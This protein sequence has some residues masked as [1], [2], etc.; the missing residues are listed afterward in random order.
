VLVEAGQHWQAEAVTQSRATICALLRHAG[1]AQGG[2]WHP[3]RARLAQVV[4]TITARTDRFVFTGQFQGGEIIAK[5]GTVIAYDGE[6]P[7]TTPE[8][9]LM[10]VLPSPCAGR[11][12]TAV[13][14]ARLTS[15]PPAA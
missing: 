3:P 10:L 14:L 15:P 2:P 7:V 6:T 5:A 9:N 8:D 1:M 12:H 4:H 13:R 11:G